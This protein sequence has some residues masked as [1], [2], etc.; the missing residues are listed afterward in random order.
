MNSDHTQR[1][2]Y[3]ILAI[4]NEPFDVLGMCEHSVCM[5]WHRDRVLIWDA[6]ES[7]YIGKPVRHHFHEMI[8]NLEKNKYFSDNWKRL[9]DL[10]GKRTMMRKKFASYA[11]KNFHP[12]GRSSAEYQWNWVKH[13]SMWCGKDLRRK[14]YEIRPYRVGS[15]FCPVT[16]DF[17][18]RDAISKDQI[19]WNK[20]VWRN[21][22]FMIKK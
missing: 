6:N 20:Y 21:P 2:Y 12:C 14:G 10:K 22:R 15:K 5:K 19:P 16:I 4:R 13:Y 1:K 18:E 11:Y 8:K 17:T 7:D 9:Q 3:I